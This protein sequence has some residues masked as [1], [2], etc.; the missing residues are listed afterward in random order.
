MNSE[1]FS[2]VREILAKVLKVDVQEVKLQS[3]LQDDLGIDSV[4]FWDIV[5]T[6]D[7]KYKVRISEEEAASM[8][9]VFDMIE[10]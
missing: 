8:K 2:G 9:S 5:A 7:K 10:A 6:L 1:L 3:K 4:D